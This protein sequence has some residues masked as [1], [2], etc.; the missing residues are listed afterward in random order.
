MRDT[1]VDIQFD[2][3]AVTL[4]PFDTF[5]EYAEAIEQLAQDRH[6]VITGIVVDGQN[7]QALDSQELA[8]LDPGAIGNLEVG[9]E[10][11]RSLS[12]SILYDTARYLPRLSRG[13]EQVAELVQRREETPAM[14]LLQ[15]CLSTWM[16]L[17]TGMR[18]AMITLGL[19][20]E[21]ITLGENNLANV[22][23]DILELLAE[24]SEV[25]ED[26]DLLDLSDLLEYEV[27]PRLLEVQEGIYHMINLAER[28]LH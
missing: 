19:D 21:E 9:T 23:E 5:G 4:G 1:T 27:A 3:E 26:G 17:T 6:R 24:V 22:Y 28:K 10:N 7:Y 18:G 2:G 25:M 16:E 20:L 15:E 14:D 11:P 12:I 13:F 8:G